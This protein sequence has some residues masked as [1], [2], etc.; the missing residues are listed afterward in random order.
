VQGTAIVRF[1]TY[2]LDKKVRG[3]IGKEARLIVQELI[4]NALKHSKANEISVQI[5]QIDGVLGIIIEDNG[6]GFDSDNIIKGVGLMS[7]EERCSKLGGSVIFE[8]GQGKGTTVFIDIPV[9]DK[10]N[11]KENPLLYAGAN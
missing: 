10:N 4:T 9:D 8:T 11:L 6:I 7:I 2:N 3:N 1:H 5:N